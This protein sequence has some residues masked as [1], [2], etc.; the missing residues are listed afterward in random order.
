MRY[1]LIISYN[2]NIYSGLQVQKDKVTI[3]GILEDTLSKVLR[4]E[5]SVVASGRTDAGVSAI[6]QV[7]HIDINNLVDER[8]LIGYTNSLLPSDIR[9]IDIIRVDET[10]HA[11]FS[12]KRKTYEYLFYLGQGN[13]PVYDNIATYIGYNVDINAMISACK[14]F[15]GEHDFSAF[16]ASNTDV[17]D[18]VRTI[19]DMSITPINDRLYKLSITGNGFLYNMVRI[20]MGTLV[21]VGLNKI[22][23]EDI[24]NIISSKDR[25]KSGKTMPSKGLYLKKVDY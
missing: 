7:C 19:F 3:Q 21:G 4:E 9:V 15:I 5:V 22:R 20:I 12:S 24:P 8:R 11:R 6:E 25:G 2:G 14:Y 18:K 17:K 23:L 13:I 16:C 10:F 1:K